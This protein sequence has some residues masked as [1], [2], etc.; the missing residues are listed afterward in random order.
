MLKNHFQVD[1][2]YPINLMRDFLIAGISAKCMNSSV[3]VIRGDRGTREK[4]HYTVCK[5][6][7][8]LGWKTAGGARPSV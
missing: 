8:K 7:L 4:G 5:P 2:L 1:K 3:P 6:K